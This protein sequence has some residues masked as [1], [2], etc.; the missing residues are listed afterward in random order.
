MKLRRRYK[1]ADQREVEQ[2]VYRATPAGT[3]EIADLIGLSQQ[4]TAARLRALDV[5]EKIWSKKVG[6]TMVWMHPRVMPDPDP[7]RDTS[8]E[9]VPGRIFGDVYR[10][11]RNQWPFGSS[12]RRRRTVYPRPE[13]LPDSSAP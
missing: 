7:D 5:R 1:R 2:A 9:D 4:C 11:S 3:K 6:P 13:D 12:P 8:A 10:A